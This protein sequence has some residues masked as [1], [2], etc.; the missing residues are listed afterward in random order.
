M[1]LQNV[2]QDPRIVP[3]LRN[4]RVFKEIKVNKV[5]PK[6]GLS[7]FRVPLKDNFFPSNGISNFLNRLLIH[8]TN[9]NS[10]DGNLITGIIYYCRDRFCE[11]LS[12]NWEISL[13]WLDA[14]SGRYKDLCQGETNFAKVCCKV[15]PDV[16]PL[17][18]EFDKEQE[19]Q[20]LNIV[21]S[22][23]NDEGI[24]DL[25]TI[26][27]RGITSCQNWGHEPG[28]YSECIVGTVLDPHVGVIY[29]EDENQKTPFGSKMLYRAIV[30][31]LLK[32]NNGT[33]KP[34]LFIDN[35]YPD[36]K[37][38]VFNLFQKALSERINGIIP[39]IEKNSIITDY[40]LPYSKTRED[41]LRITGKLLC[42]N[43]QYDNFIN[44]S[45][46]FHK[47]LSYRDTLI[48][49]ELDPNCAFV[50]P[51][52]LRRKIHYFTFPFNGEKEVEVRGDF[53]EKT[54]E[55]GIPMRLE[56]NEWKAHFPR[57][58]GKPMQYK[59]YADRQWRIDVN[60]PSFMD[61]N[62][63]INN[64]LNLKLKNVNRKNNK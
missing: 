47:I 16:K 51:Q 64:I 33:D 55:K 42:L 34:F 9:L 57:R 19:G 32:K 6:L 31:L 60:K 44:T 26:S 8:F 46:N 59:F 28:R 15:S 43:K 30:R 22:S 39:V 48:S 63:N 38:G 7:N 25:L 17:F 5:F 40:Y 35:I 11:H 24:W 36:Y 23:S 29:I 1:S 58:V 18:D 50:P 3:W 54:W 4:H 12:T 10:N 13:N 37:E 2:L 41:I 21:F 14:A 20:K 49:I 27:K 45:F 62:G 53:G 61:E 52:E 56:G